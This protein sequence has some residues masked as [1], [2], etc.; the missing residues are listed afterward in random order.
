MKYCQQCGTQ[1]SDDAAVCTCGYRFA[2]TASGTLPPPTTTASDP[3]M[4]TPHDETVVSRAG[5][6]LLVGGILMALGA[7]YSLFNISDH[8]EVASGLAVLTVF[9]LLASGLVVYGAIAMWT[10]TNHSLSVIASV[11][12]IIG[13]LFSVVFWI[14][15]PISIWALITLRKAEAKRVFPASTVRGSF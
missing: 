14:V 15:L 10:R 5:L 7:L 3:A 2:A 9:P 13:S 8:P 12:G 6:V 1:T 4:L 11:A